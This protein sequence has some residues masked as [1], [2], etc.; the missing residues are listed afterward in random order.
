MKKFIFTGVLCVLVGVSFG[1]KK[2]VS[3]AKNEIKGNSPNIAE[4]RSLIN[5]AL[6]NPETSNDAE[7]WYVAGQI[8]NK[9]FDV[10]K[11]NEILGKQPNEE[12]MYNA[13]E[14]IIPFF[15]KAAELDQL[16]D[17]KGK[18]KPRFLKDIRSIILANRMYY[19]NAGVFAFNKSNYQKAYEN[20]KQFG[21]ILTM[22]LFKDEKLPFTQ[23]DT[24]NLQIRYYA[25]MAAS[26]IPNPQAAITIYTEMIKEGYVEN[27]LFTESDVYNH[28][29][30]EYNS[31]GDT[32]AFE[33]I[34]REG[35]LKFPSDE[36]FMLSMINLSINS[37]KSEE[38]VSYLEKAIAQSPDNAQLYA[39]LGQ[40]YYEDKKPEPAIRYLQRA[41]EMEP[42]NIAFLSELGRVY[43]NLGVEKR[44]M[45]DEI[46]DIAQSRE[47]AK[48]AMDFYRQAMPFYE[49]V[50]DLD[51]ENRDAI[52]ALRNIYYSL[53]MGPQFKKID[54][55]FNSNIQDED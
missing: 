28:L 20:F 19:I 41:L 10:E 46:S 14:K 47:V 6:A 7:T 36:F 17:V 11:T 16:P 33:K 51:P 54:D 55:I 37:G 29:A 50:F 22:E 24:T 35:F 15:V 2:A 45:A 1:Q 26:Q 18:V 49:K 40:L 21:D 13:L 3:A 43:F 5:G 4:A 32:A 38:A 31:A 27:G 53:E 9:Q 39:V 44:K 8:E 42:D 48:E 23:G 30:R 25:G 52:F 34:I 12:V